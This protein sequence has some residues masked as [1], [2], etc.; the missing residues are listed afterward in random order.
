MKRA[1]CGTCIGL[2]AWCSLAVPQRPS[3]ADSEALLA[4]SREKAI[5]YAHSLPDF[6]ATELIHRFTGSE[7]VKGFWTPTDTLT[8][9]VRY[10]QHKDDHKLM[11]IDGKSTRQTF[12]TLEGTIGSGEFGT[13]LRDIFDPAS[14]TTFHWQSWKNVR[15]QRASVF[16]YEVNGAHSRYRLGTT[17]DGRALEAD[18]GY[19][20]VVEIDPE[21]GEVLHLEYVADHI[22]EALHLQYA[23]NTVDYALT[24]IGGQN[25]LLPSRSDTEMRGQSRWAR[26]VTEFRDYR[27]F[28]AESTIDFGTGK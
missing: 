17:A 20:G 3:D 6:V 13:T 14:Q 16:G 23:G 21:T 15:K 11:L 26:N 2:L 24:D 25:Y 9:Q 5:K 28:S 8:I 7:A 27:K 10:F 18:V 4:R 1:L 22:P 12:E 19:H